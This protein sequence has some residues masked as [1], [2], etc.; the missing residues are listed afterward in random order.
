MGLGKEAVGRTAQ[1]EEGPHFG[2][3]GLGLEPRADAQDIRRLF[4][5]SCSTEG[6]FLERH[7]KLAPVNTFT[8]G[9]FIAGACQGPRDIPDAVA[10]AGAAAAEALALIDRGEVELE[11]NTAY[12]KAEECSGCKSC[13]P[14]CPYSAIGF[15]EA[16]KKA[17]INEALCK[18]CGTCVA[19]CP[20]GSIQQN[21]FDDEEIF[22]EIE[23]LFPDRA[24]LA[25]TTE[26]IA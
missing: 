16:T 11:P 21:L 14:L 10:Q 3:I 20:S 7:P 2:G 5:I 1:A 13:I 23:G 24:A 4:N 12:V 26:V 22:S 9:I 6:F 18:G 17:A 15:D 19:S 25:S 8:D